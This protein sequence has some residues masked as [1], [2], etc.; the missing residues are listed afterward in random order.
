[1]GFR[2]QKFE[3]IKTGLYVK[4]KD[5]LDPGDEHIRMVVLDDFGA[6]SDRCL[7]KDLTWKWALGSTRVVLKKE[8][9][10]I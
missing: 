2:N 9:T 5:I 6:D 1:M 8:L 7:V 3:S 10:T 4:F